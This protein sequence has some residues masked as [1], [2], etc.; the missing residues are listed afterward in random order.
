MLEPREAPGVA[1]IDRNIYV[2]G[3]IGVEGQPLSSAER[4]DLGAGTWTKLP[5]MSRP[6]SD[7]AMLVVG[8]WLYVY[9][10]S[11]DGHTAWPMQRFDVDACVWEQLP[12]FAC[13]DRAGAE[14]A[15]VRASACSS[16]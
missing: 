1:V 9:H 3:G 11:N 2:C 14:A 6:F 5:P 10:D 13:M 12:D 4:Y 15:M 8:R 16:A 7:T